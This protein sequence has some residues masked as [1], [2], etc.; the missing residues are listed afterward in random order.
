MIITSS[1]FHS[2]VDKQDDAGVMSKKRFSVFNWVHE[3]YNNF[4]PHQTD[5]LSPLMAVNESEN[6]FATFVDVR[7]R[8]FTDN[9]CLMQDGVYKEG[10]LMEK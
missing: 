1:Q 10:P 3:E 8:Q 7:S 2:G 6:I 5:C 4:I 9:L